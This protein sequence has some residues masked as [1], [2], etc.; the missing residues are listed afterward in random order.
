MSSSR[1]S[2]GPVSGAPASPCDL[3]TM[4]PIDSASACCCSS[5][6]PSSSPSA[7]ACCTRLISASCRCWCAARSCITRST[8]TATAPPTWLF[9][10]S[11]GF[12]VQLG[13]K[14]G[15]PPAVLSAMDH[16]PLTRTCRQSGRWPSG[17]MRSTVTSPAG[18]ATV[19]QYLRKTLVSHVHGRRVYCC[20]EEEGSRSTVRHTWREHAKRVAIRTS[21]A[22]RRRRP[23]CS[24]PAIK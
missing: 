3:T 14:L 9:S 1:S 20:V 8:P 16:A 7:T 10:R 12:C 13:G 19:R 17:S 22:S 11:C 23:L 21:S 4:K 24:G 15:Q 5:A 6:A 2:S 18:A